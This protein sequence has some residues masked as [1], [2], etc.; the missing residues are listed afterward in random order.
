MPH[1]SLIRENFMIIAARISLI[2]KEMD[3][4]VFNSG[5][6][7]FSLDVLKAIGFVPAG[8]EDIEGDHA[9]NGEPI[10]RLDVEFLFEAARCKW[11][12]KNFT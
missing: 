12:E 2:A 1:S 6:I 8:W 3:C 5:N 11:V 10:W 4:L 7:L 9:S